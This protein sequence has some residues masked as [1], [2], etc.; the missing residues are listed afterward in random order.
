[1]KLALGLAG[2][3]AI[4]APTSATADVV[5]TLRARIQPQC[6]VIDVTAAAGSADITVRTACNVERFQLTVGEMGEPAIATASGQNA[7]VFAG[8]DGTIAVTVDNPGIQTVAITLDAP[9]G[10]EMPV[11]TLQ[12]A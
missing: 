2:A 3:L 4:L 7:A 9:L 8:L 12:A 10:E 6:Q 11:I 5:F 1:M